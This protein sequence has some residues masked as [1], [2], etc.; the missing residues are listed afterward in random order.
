[1]SNEFESMGNRLIRFYILITLISVLAY[2]CINS[3]EED[4]LFLDHT[5]RLRW[6]PG[7]FD[8]SKEEVRTGFAW[9][10]SSLGAMLPAGSMDQV[11]IEL[12]ENLFEIDLSHAGFSEEALG[13]LNVVLTRLKNSQAYQVNNYI[14][15]GRFI[16]LTLNS[17]NHYYEI[18][19]VPKNLNDF[20]SRYA[21]NG[22]QMRLIKSSISITPRLF[23]IADATKFEEIA[24]LAVEGTG[25]FEDN[26]FNPKE[27]E[28]F[29]FL[30]NGQLRFAI[31]D[32]NGKLK[33]V[34]D[35]A[36]TIAGKP[37]KCLW[38]HETGIQPL[39]QENPVLSGDGFI[40]EID[41]TV[42]RDRQNLFLAEYRGSLTNEINFFELQD[43]RFQEYLYIDFM[44]PTIERIAME[45]DMDI[46]DVASILQDIPVHTQSEY[47]IEN[48]YHRNDIERLAPF[49]S[50]E[51]PESAREP[52][53]NEPNFFVF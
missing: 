53:S 14:E 44:E 46:D 35:E 42:I 23:E 49:T 31:Y 8:Q 7:A 37:G 18:T 10:L 47:L 20:R 9:T 41:F 29:D 40:S 15:M 3:T 22:T 5:I 1:M 38:C 27:F 33:E 45:W 32:I 24:Y 50:T 16:M 13:A 17:S 11:M 21:F 19:Q 51:V 48:V 26:S 2:S 52:S 34:A 12:D 28:V 30:P 39:F 4:D 25:K 6:F 36:I 43:H